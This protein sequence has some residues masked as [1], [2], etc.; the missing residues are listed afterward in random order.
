MFQ[1]HLGSKDT[2]PE[3]VSTWRS[4]VVPQLLPPGE[5][6]GL[7]FALL[8]SWGVK[9]GPACKSTKEFEICFG[10]FNLELFPFSSQTA[11]S[12]FPVWRTPKWT[13]DTLE[14]GQRLSSFHSFYSSFSKFVLVRSAHGLCVEVRG[15]P[16]VSIPHTFPTAGFSGC[17]CT[18]QVSR[19]TSFCRFSCLCFPS[20]RRRYRTTPSFTWVL[21][22]W[23][24]IPHSCM[25]SSLCTDPSIQSKIFPFNG[26]SG[27][28]YNQL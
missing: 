10:Q 15:Q 5:N 11:W 7:S 13:W 6:L 12:C 8:Q 25:A 4:Q 14:I 22:I 27:F 21:G 24:H 2:L 28:W 9:S 17:P 23:T 26:K 16:R 1:R 3:G 19:P 18:Y 20:L